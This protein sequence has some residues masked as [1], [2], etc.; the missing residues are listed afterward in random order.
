MTSIIFINLLRELH[1]LLII[2][3]AH[4][5]SHS[6][7]FNTAIMLLNSWRL[8]FS[9]FFTTIFIACSANAMPSTYQWQDQT[10]LTKNSE[11]WQQYVRSP[12]NRTIYPQS[13]V[14]NLTMGNVTNPSGLLSPS[15]GVTTL[16]RSN[17]SATPPTIVID[18]GQN[19]VGFLSINFAGAS[20]NSP[21]VRL[22]F[23]ETLE[24]LTNISD[25]TRSFNVSEAKLEERAVLTFTGRHNHSW[26]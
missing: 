2:L 1:I 18:F 15:G 16:Y 22:A 14:S 5:Y 3:L 17:G 21:G 23:S 6:L 24:Y 19:I 10:T 13:I 9:L 4:S 7:I 26:N 8:P 11:S 12:Q 20:D 25:F